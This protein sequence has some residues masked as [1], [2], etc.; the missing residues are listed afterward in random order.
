[1]LKV[2]VAGGIGFYP[3]ADNLL[4]VAI[5]PIY[6]GRQATDVVGQRLRCRNLVQAFVLFV[7]VAG[8][9]HIHFSELRPGADGLHIVVDEIAVGRRDNGIQPQALVNDGSLDVPAVHLLS[10]LPP[11]GIEALGYRIGVVFDGITAGHS[12]L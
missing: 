2:D 11:T 4:L 5:G 12:V 7:D 9:N 6:K 8:E 10:L 1:M 3:A